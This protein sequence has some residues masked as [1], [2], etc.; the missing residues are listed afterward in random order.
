LIC[1]TVNVGWTCNTV[2]TPV[3]SMTFNVNILVAWLAFIF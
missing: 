3:M 1:F 2:V